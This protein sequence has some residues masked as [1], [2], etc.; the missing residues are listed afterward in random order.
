ML[1]DP[2][3][4]ALELGDEVV[5]MASAKNF[6]GYGLQSPASA[7]GALIVA[8]PEAPADTPARNSNDST[9][10]SIV[11]QMPEVPSESTGGLSIL[12]YSLE[13]NSGGT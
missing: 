2:L 3:S 9:E 7:A 1:I 10:T 12:S 13:W 4:F 11:V 8:K 6:N 5:V